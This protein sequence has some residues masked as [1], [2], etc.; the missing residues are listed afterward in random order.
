M[1]PQKQEG[2]S[3]QL[4]EA[5]ML[6]ALKASTLTTDQ[7]NKLYSQV[8]KILSDTGM[9]AK[10]KANYEAVE[11]YKIRIREK[12]QDPL[13]FLEKT[14]PNGLYTK[15]EQAEEVGVDIMTKSFVIGLL[16]TFSVKKDLIGK[17]IRWNGNWS[18]DFRKGFYENN[19]IVIDES[20]KLKNTGIVC[21]GYL[22]NLWAGMGKE[23]EG[24]SVD[25][26]FIKPIEE[27]GTD[28]VCS[29]IETQ[30]LFAD[31]INGKMSEVDLK[32]LE[33]EFID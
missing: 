5:I 26:F 21:F 24:Y 8:Y 4:T 15:D 9:D 19:T 33:F 28:H 29:Q 31:F 14:F 25:G 30:S 11:A 2:F 32:D 10:M 27:L 1:Q 6:V 18:H 12:Y 23:Y 16:E 17:K 22:G 20:K 7:Y 13:S 3:G